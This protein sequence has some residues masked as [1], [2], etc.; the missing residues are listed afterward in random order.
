MWPAPSFAARLLV[1]NKGPTGVWIFIFSSRARLTLDLNVAAGSSSNDFSSF[2][3]S[4]RALC[5]TNFLRPKSARVIAQRCKNG[6]EKCGVKRANMLTTF[7]EPFQK[8][9]FTK[10]SHWYILWCSAVWEGCLSLCWALDLIRYRASTQLCSLMQ[11]GHDSAASGGLQ[12]DTLPQSC[13]AG[14]LGWWMAWCQYIFLIPTIQPA[15]WGSQPKKGF[16]DHSPALLTCRA[17]CIAF[18]IQNGA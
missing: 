16:T 2:S 18:C 14:K 10:Q 4:L 17:F 7:I 9:H 5:E 15:T 13:C 12:L 3:N 8:K 11:R 1:V 6:I